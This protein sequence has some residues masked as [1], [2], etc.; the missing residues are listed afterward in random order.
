MLGSNSGKEIDLFETVIRQKAVGKHILDN[1]PNDFGSKVSYICGSWTIQNSL[2]W[3]PVPVW[4]FCDSRHPNVKLS[5]NEN[6]TVLL[7]KCNYWNEFYRNKRTAGYVRNKKMAVHNTSSEVGHNHMSCG[8][9]T[10]MYACE[11]LKPS[12]ICLYG[13]D[14]IKSGDF[15][16]SLTRGKDWNQYPDHRW[17]IENILLLEFQERYNV[18]FEFR[19]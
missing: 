9:H 18:H 7:D 2:F 12:K 3:A 4:V 14:N 5:G 13:F 19:P 16:W 15:T 11:I 17:D 1:N 10:I 8:L 6:F